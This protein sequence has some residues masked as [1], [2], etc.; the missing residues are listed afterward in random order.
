MGRDGY[1]WRVYKDMEEIGDG[2]IQVTVVDFVWKGWTD[3]PTEKELIQ[4]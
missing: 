3:M 4:D 2:P 1:K